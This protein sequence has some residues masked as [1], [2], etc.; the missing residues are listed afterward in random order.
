MIKIGLIT[1]RGYTRRQIKHCKGKTNV[2]RFKHRFGV[3]PCTAVCVYTDLHQTTTS[4]CSC[5]DQG[6]RARSQ[7]LFHGDSTHMTKRL[8]WNSTTQPTT[9]REKLGRWR[10]KLT[11]EAQGNCLGGGLPAGKTI[12]HVSGSTVGSTSQNMKME[13]RPNVVLSQLQQSRS[14]LRVGNLASG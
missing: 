7:V 4:H 3:S 9:R 12:G 10:K 2:F 13:S 14:W 1:T 8:E 5:Q 6:R 11:V